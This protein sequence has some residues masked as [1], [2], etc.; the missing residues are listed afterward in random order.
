MFAVTAAEALLSGLTHSLCQSWQ[1]TYCSERTVTDR[2]AN[3]RIR[4]PLL[5]P[6][7]LRDHQG[8]CSTGVGLTHRF[9]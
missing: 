7:E 3:N 1:L 4:K 9:G 5:Y 8:R 6:A 2:N